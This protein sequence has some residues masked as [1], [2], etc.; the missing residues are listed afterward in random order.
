[1]FF[2]EQRKFAGLTS[3]QGLSEGLHRPLTAVGGSSEYLLDPALFRLGYRVD[4]DVRGL[5]GSN[6]SS[7]FCVDRTPVSSSGQSF[8]PHHM[9]GSFFQQRDQCLDPHGS[10]CTMARPPTQHLSPFIEPASI[11]LPLR[12]SSSTMSDRNP[13]LVPR[14]LFGHTIPGSMGLP[15]FSLYPERTEEK[16]AFVALR[17]GAEKSVL[18][19][20][21]LEA[22]SYA[23]HLQRL[24]EHHVQ[25]NKCVGACCSPSLGSLSQPPKSCSCCSSPQT[26]VCGRGPIG[27]LGKET[28]SGK[29]CNGAC[30][31]FAPSF[32]YLGQHTAASDVRLNMN[33]YYPNLGEP[34]RREEP[35]G[36]MFSWSSGLAAVPINNVL[37]PAVSPALK[38]KDSTGLG[39]KGSPRAAKDFPGYSTPT[40]RR[41]SVVKQRPLQNSGHNMEKLKNESNCNEVIVIEDGPTIKCAKQHLSK[42]SSKPS[43]HNA[44]RKDHNQKDC[45]K[46]LSAH[47]NKLG[48]KN[49]DHSEN[50]VKMPRL[51]AA[52]KTKTCSENSQLHETNVSA[53]PPLTAAGV[54]I[55]PTKTNVTSSINPPLWNPH[56]T[57]SITSAVATTQTSAIAPIC[58]QPFE[59]PFTKEERTDVGD[60]KPAI[61]L[62]NNHHFDQS[63]TTSL[64]YGINSLTRDIKPPALNSEHAKEPGCLRTTSSSKEH[65]DTC[66]HQ[67]VKKHDMKHPEKGSCFSSAKEDHG[68]FHCQ[69]SKTALSF[70]PYSFTQE[71]SEYTF[72]DS[73]DINSP[74]DSG[75]LKASRKRFMVECLVNSDGYIS[76]K[77]KKKFSFSD[78]PKLGNEEMT[79]QITSS[80]S[81]DGTTPST[82]QEEDTSKTNRGSEPDNRFEDLKKTGHVKTKHQNHSGSTDKSLTKK[83][84]TAEF[85]EGFRKE[86]KR[87]CAKAKKKLRKRLLAKLYEQQ[88]KSD[89]ESE[90]EELIKNATASKSPCSDNQVVSQ[91]SLIWRQR[92]LLYSCH[93]VRRRKLKS[94]LDMI[95]KPHRKKK[96][97]SQSIE[98]LLKKD[99]LKE[100]AHLAPL[101][102]TFEQIGEK[103][104]FDFSN[105][106]PPEMKRIM[107]NKALGETIL[108]RAARLGYA[109][110]VLYCLGTNYC[111]VNARDNAGYTPLHESC[112]RGNLEIAS[113]LVQYGADVSA[114]AAGGIRPLHDAVENDHVEIVRLLLSH[115]ADPT[116]ATYSGLT[117]LKLARSSIM[118]KFLRGFLADATGETESGLVLPWKFQGSSSCLDTKETGYDIWEGLP[119]DSENETEEKDDFLFEDM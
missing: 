13:P 56:I 18:N 118:A 64:S 107:V 25:Q 106:A 2:L 99:F 36:S 74:T 23:E 10:I 75:G 14:G 83:F 22:T 27:C 38:R 84:K 110:V 76:L 40:E 55:S 46:H 37:A 3:S 12:P 19:G 15:S 71:K 79:L 7:P 86:A 87:V 31:Y 95:A 28:P 103:V 78:P 47:D 9:M 63:V 29:L 117:S 91:L 50:N 41:D 65:T 90:N 67:Q 60:C 100:K 62:S 92:R 48:S 70:D 20:T 96:S 58:H 39:L 98:K 85:E 34:T 69:P 82:S 114:S 53:P 108:H 5:M 102:D 59:S 101:E 49:I 35:L 111:D 44:K 112:S 105:G 17:P 93:T 61:N 24:R 88:R 43:E 16:G 73:E 4:S 97:K 32:P 1:M 45:Q 116:I 42:S 77:K 115:G 30:G 57:T 51:D 26:V 11:P 119:L 6:I 21:P 94:G 68:R 52:T 113:A 54:T 8:G 81:A 80:S 72:D 109:E 104:S 89:P 66:L 33:P